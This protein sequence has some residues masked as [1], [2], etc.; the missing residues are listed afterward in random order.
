MYNETKAGNWYFFSD[1]C[2]LFFDIMSIYFYI[3]TVF[4]IVANG[5]LLIQ[6]F[7]SCGKK[8]DFRQL[9][10]FKWNISTLMGQMLAVFSIFFYPFVHLAGQ[11]LANFMNSGH[12]KNG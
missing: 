11:R 5:I 3:L 12:T 8:A 9:I 4:I 6:Y 2:N 7:F 1:E 10:L